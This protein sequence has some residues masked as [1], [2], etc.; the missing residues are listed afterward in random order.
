[1]THDPV[2]LLAATAV[3]LAFAW[4]CV[5][6]LRR[7]APPRP[8]E[9]ATLIAYAS[10][11]GFAEALARSAA[12]ALE[13]A[14]EPAGVVEL[15]DLTG[16]ALAQARTLLFVAATTGAGEPPDR[17]LRF[18]R[19]VMAETL[20]LSG[21]QVGLLALGD[22]SYAQF[23]AF[24]R[25]LD[26]WLGACGAHRLFPTVEVD[27]GDP[28]ALARWREA[29]AE[30][31][32]G[33]DLTGDEAADAPAF[34]LSARTL[35]NPDGVGDPAFLLALT[36]R[37]ALPG[38][39]AGDVVEVEREGPAGAIRREYSIASLPEDGAIELIVRRFQRDGG[40]TGAMSGWLTDELP[41]DGPVRLRVRA[42]AS[43]RA[44]ADAAPLILIGSGTGLAG[45]RAHVRALRARGDG[46]RAWLVFG[47]RARATD[48]LLGDEVEGWR[49]QGI[50]G[51]LDLAFSRDGEGP[52]YVQDIL[53]RE[54]A[55]VRARLQA[56]ASLFV[57]GRQAM[58][59]GVD[60]AL[61]EILGGRA[62]V[63][64]LRETGRYRRDV[65]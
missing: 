27:A 47:E 19:R 5:A 21:L 60:T 30:W 41:L 38:W 40:A 62:Q 9:G 34:R 53:R 18:A 24:G 20:D 55:E 59:Q 6:C 31:R 25:Q 45:L 22:R 28:A 58:G 7:R 29:L 39:S 16:E 42:N 35:L 57:C 52:R 3:A 13:R 65:Y 46:A 32:P 14:G 23:C 10:Q 15:G 12:A 44:P 36:P 33:A 11:T 43:F 61:A 54:A 2:R 48:F 51:R 17:A 56:G 64:A 50:V 1:M 63:D 4:L 37:A 26:G 8:A 49:A